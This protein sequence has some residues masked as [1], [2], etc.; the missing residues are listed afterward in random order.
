MCAMLYQI[1]MMKY[2]KSHCKEGIVSFVYRTVP[3]H[4]MAYF[5]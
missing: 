1:L 5:Q 3:V 2:L 4:I